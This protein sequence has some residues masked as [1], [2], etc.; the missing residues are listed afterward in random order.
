MNEGCNCYQQN[1]QFMAF[2]S[3]CAVVALITGC[4]ELQLPVLAVCKIYE[5]AEREYFKTYLSITSLIQLTVLILS[6]DE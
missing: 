5:N 3:D 4:F 2:L 1:E 6:N